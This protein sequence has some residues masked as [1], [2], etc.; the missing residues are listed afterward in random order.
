MVAAAYLAVNGLLQADVA[1]APFPASDAFVLTWIAS[2]AFTAF[3]VEVVDE[4]SA[5][6]MPPS[7]TTGHNAQCNTDPKNACG[8]E[9]P[10]K[11]CLAAGCC[12]EEQA[13]WACWHPAPNASSSFYWSSGVVASNSTT[14]LVLPSVATNGFIADASYKWRVRVGDPMHA[15][16]WSETA[17]FDVAP[18]AAQLAGSSW[19]GG[20][21]E[22]QTDFMIPSGVSVVRARAYASGL[23]AFELHVNGEKVGDHIMDPGEAV[24]DQ[25]ALYV[26]FNITEM[27]QQSR[28]TTATATAANAGNVTHAI[29]ARIGNSKWGWL[30]IYS[31]R[32][33]LGDQS[34]DSSRAFFL[35]LTAQLA[36]GRVMTLRTSAGA[37]SS[38]MIRHG[39]I[40]YDHLWHGEI[41]DARQELAAPTWTTAP[42]ASY[43]A[44]AGWT[45]AKAM[46]P[47]VGALFPQLMP[48]IR[49][50]ADHAAVSTIQ[51]TSWNG[52]AASAMRYDFGQNMAG[53][54]T[55]EFTKPPAMTTTT[56]DAD[57]YED[58]T[59]IM[60]R[61]RHSEIRGAPDGIHD[62]N[63]YPGMEFNHASAT[64]SM[65]D[66]YA[67]TWYECANQTD[68]VVFTTAKPLL[69]F[70]PTFTYHGFRFIELVA[71]EIAADGTEHPLSPALAASF[72]WGA[73]IT[74]HRVNSDLQPLTKVNFGTGGSSTSSTRSTRSED[75]SMITRIYDA[76]MAAH[77]SQLWG[78]PTDCPQREKRGWM[79]DAGIS[80]VSL[81][82]FFDSFAFHTNFLRLI[83]DN[84]VKGCWNQPNTTIYGACTT[85]EPM[86][87][88]KWFN[89]SVPD[90]TPFPTGPYG[91]N[92]GSTDWQVAY[93]CVAWTQLHHHGAAVA[94]PML[95]DLW[96][97]L[98]LF[99][100]YLERLVDPV[101]GLLLTGA[102][103][104]WI[105]PEGN[106]KGPWPTPP[107]PI[108]AFFHTLCVSHM[109]DIANAIGRAD[110]AKRYTTRLAKNQAAYH[111]MFYNG[112]ADKGAKNDE[113]MMTNGGL[114]RCCYDTGSQTNNVMALVIGAVPT[115]TL[116]KATVGM[117]VASIKD[118]NATLPSRLDAPL[119]ADVRNTSTALSKNDEWGWT[120]PPWGAGLHIDVGIFGTTW[121]FETLRKYEQDAVGLAV[122]TETSY[123]SLGRMIVQNA[124][125][126]WGGEWMVVAYV[127][128][129]FCAFLCSLLLSFS[130][131]LV[132]SFLP[133]FLPSFLRSVGWRRAQHW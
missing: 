68:A 12:W 75:A 63:F 3:E 99:M 129:M 7:A 38:W 84:Q 2:T 104:D 98:D 126:L 39:P 80:S 56:G 122:L 110:D 28:G 79:G 46:S 102:R 128:N 70:T 81:G 62:N 4:A 23:G 51:Q 57:G 58:A 17:T 88:A 91:G 5:W 82:M 94:G 67:R 64:C 45:S 96:A 92:P 10:L 90:V 120:P 123:P 109:A 8:N 65:V 14:S 111:K 127:L 29:G 121:I 74:A 76:T 125:T 59:T 71:T 106:M 53:Y 18:T 48:P 41:Y 32:S 107:K 37:Q 27:L 11:E 119:A 43:A 131:S 34:G 26:G 66:W 19:I 93:V 69:K 101:T 95:A 50:I 20:G 35:Y 54:A 44:A 85:K 55:L 33:E 112:K 83:R 60:V 49:V 30:D 1:S 115:P 116:I 105:P 77:V 78:I 61:L 86:G 100:D 21:S 15:A 42:L 114:Q 118:R 25:K 36:D 73:K 132:A 117:L 6:M 89:G 133:S 103:G 16:T 72:P 113:V 130:P 52:T 47:K 87:A 97:S 24:Y 40:V 31:N 22:M 13:D 124:T 108:A 9:L